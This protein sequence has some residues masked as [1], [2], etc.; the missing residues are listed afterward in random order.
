MPRIC[1]CA[2]RDED[3]IGD[4]PLSSAS[5]H[6]KPQRHRQTPRVFSGARRGPEGCFVRASRLYLCVFVSVLRGVSSCFVVSASEATWCYT[7]PPMRALCSVIV[8]SASLLAIGGCRARE[9]A[10]PQ[11]AFRPTATVK[12]IMA[13]I[14]DPEADVLWNAVATIVSADGHRR[15]GAENR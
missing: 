5:S 12:D 1:V 15:A 10:K 2:V 8:V 13:S 4:D 3:D 9:E 11:P 14:V 6:R 7:S